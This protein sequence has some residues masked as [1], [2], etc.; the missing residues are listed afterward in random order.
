MT[1]QSCSLCKFAK[2]CSLLCS[3]CRVPLQNL[4]GC[5]K[6]IQH[7]N[8]RQLCHHFHSVTKLPIFLQIHTC[9]N[10]HF[11]HPVCKN[12]AI[13]SKAISSVQKHQAKHTGTLFNKE[14]WNTPYQCA[15]LQFEHQILHPVCK[16]AQSVQ[17]ATGSVQMH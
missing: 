3:T 15:N 7:I 2:I 1:S 17:Y 12:C 11:L 9:R 5:E 14:G 10:D 6:D 13:C 16:S 4:Q 8:L